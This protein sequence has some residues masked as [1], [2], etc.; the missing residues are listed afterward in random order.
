MLPD[1]AVLGMPLEDAIVEG[2][3][4]DRNKFRDHVPEPVRRV[5]RKALAFDPAK[6][7]DSAWAL[8]HDIE[9]VMPELSFVELGS[10]DVAEWSGINDTHEW[11]ASIR[12]DNLTT[13]RFEIR[14]R[15]KGNTTRG[16]RQISLPI[17]TPRSRPACGGYSSRE[18]EVSRR[19]GYRWNPRLEQPPVRATM[20]SRR[21]RLPTASDDTCH[22]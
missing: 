3:F 17:Q 22:R 11:E 2:K 20:N 9:R 6:R 21:G 7:T 12:Q 18:A 15:K 8:R 13:Y 19:T 10:R 5:V 14:R 16:R 4:P 1:P